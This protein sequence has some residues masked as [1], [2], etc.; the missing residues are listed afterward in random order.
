MTAADHSHRFVDQK[1]PPLITDAQGA[2]IHTNRLKGWI[3]LISQTGQL[4][5]DCDASLLQPLLGAAP[6]AQTSSSNQLL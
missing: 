2:A 3:R 6:G 4:V 5:V 1:H